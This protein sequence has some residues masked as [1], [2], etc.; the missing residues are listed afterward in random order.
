M[1]KPTKTFPEK[2]KG[3]IT[4]AASAEPGQIVSSIFLHPK[5]DGSYRLILNLM[6]IFNI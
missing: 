3:V 2:E 4:K 5:K 6:Y 1:E